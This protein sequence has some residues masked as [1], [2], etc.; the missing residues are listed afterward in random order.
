MEHLELEQEEMIYQQD[1]ASAH[2][3]KVCLKWLEDHG[4]EVMEWP[5][6]SPNLNPI[7]NLW[8]E[9]KRQLGTYETPPAGTLDLWERVQTEWDK[10]EPEYCRKLVDSMSKRMETILKNSGFPIKY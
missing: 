2:K 1:N 8:D 5:P 9:P 6:Y 4:I 7:E 3:A 10:I